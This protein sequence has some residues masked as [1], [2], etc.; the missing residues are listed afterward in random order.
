MRIF[1][2]EFTDL[3]YDGTEIAGKVCDK[4]LMFSN[5]GDY[6]EHISYRSQ[7]Q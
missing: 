6:C 7:N 1:M 4:T 3:T 5:K 2:R